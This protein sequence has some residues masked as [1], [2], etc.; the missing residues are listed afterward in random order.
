MEK[1]NRKL[2]KDL[3]YLIKKNAEIRSL[4]ED[5]DATKEKMKMDLQMLTRDYEKWK[6]NVEED[7]KDID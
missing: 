2:E 1:K 6:K 4:K 3:N 5:N 7:K